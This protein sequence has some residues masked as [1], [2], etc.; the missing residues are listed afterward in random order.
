MGAG[1]PDPSKSPKVV[2][3]MRQLKSDHH[4]KNPT[5][6]FDLEKLPQIIAAARV[7]PRWSSAMRIQAVCMALLRATTG[8][9]ASNHGPKAITV[10]LVR[11]PPLSEKD[12]WGA[13][14]LPN[15]LAV[16]HPEVSPQPVSPHIPHA[17]R[18]WTDGESDNWGKATGRA[19][20]V[21]Y[22][23]KPLPLRAVPCYRAGVLDAAFWSFGAR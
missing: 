6:G 2:E 5:K 21:P 23:A 17:Q 3:M 14:G 15:V 19:E 20:V 22:L 11:M 1:V 9:R 10:D 8:V 4:T 18:F 13:D 12:L 7:M 16:A